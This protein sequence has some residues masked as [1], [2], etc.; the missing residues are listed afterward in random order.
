MTDVFVLLI[1]PG[2]GDELQGV[3]RGIMEIADLI[4]VNKADGDLAAAAGRT[5]A[6][7]RNALRLLHPP[8]PGWTP[9]VRQCS[10]L[11]GAGVAAAWQT[12]ERFRAA[13]SAGGE[14]QRRRSAQARAALHRELAESLLVALRADPDVARRLAALERSVAA[15]RSSP[16]A[17]ADSLVATVLGRDAA[18]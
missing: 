8:T 4:L 9:E 10:A 13:L 17:A 15:G 14:L 5:A 1:A 16:A 11:T 12:V 3:K 6:D 18:S 7:Y 2:G